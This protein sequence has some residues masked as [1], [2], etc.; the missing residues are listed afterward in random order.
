MKKEKTEK[1]E[2]RGPIERVMHSMDLPEYLWS[3]QCHVEIIGKRQVIAE[4]IRG[5]TEYDEQFVKIIL[6]E[7]SLV[8]MGSDLLLDALEKTTVVVRGKI[9][10]VEFL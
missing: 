4:N 10:A 1:K 8:V 2:W 3:Q 7:G 9:T 5:I 6:K